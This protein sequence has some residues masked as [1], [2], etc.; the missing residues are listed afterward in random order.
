MASDFAFFIDLL[1][2]MSNLNVKMQEK[3]QFIDDIW[4]H[5]KTFKLNLFAAQ[6]AKNDLSDFLRLNSIP[7]VNEEKLKNYEDGLKKMHFEFERRFQDFSAIQ[8]KLDL[9]AMPFNVN[10]EAVKNRP[11]FSTHSPTKLRNRPG[12]YKWHRK[13][14]K[15]KKMDGCTKQKW[16]SSENIYR[17]DRSKRMWLPQGKPAINTRFGKSDEGANL[18]ICPTAAQDYDY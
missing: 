16:E 8:T 4:A 17:L 5:L 1:C 9:F 14:R 6:L 2:H 15:E 7:S 12:Y 3:N 18:K 11:L 10:C 13:K